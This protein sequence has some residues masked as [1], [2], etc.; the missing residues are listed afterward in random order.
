M[1]PASR[2]PAA[3]GEDSGWSCQGAGV[4][5]GQAVEDGPRPEHPTARRPEASLEPSRG[6]WALLGRTVTAGQVPVAGRVPEGRAVFSNGAAQTM[7]PPEEAALSAVAAPAGDQGRGSSG[8][9][10]LAPFRLQ[11]WKVSS[12]QQLS[13]LSSNEE[14]LQHRPPPFPAPLCFG[15]GLCVSSAGEG[16]Q[17]GKAFLG[18]GRVRGGWEAAAHACLHLPPL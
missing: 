7:F 15:M 5:Q 17:G 12:S 9:R 2:G 8:L 18:R 11:F 16:G 3:P 13:F 1:A 14:G 10:E 4:R 6:I